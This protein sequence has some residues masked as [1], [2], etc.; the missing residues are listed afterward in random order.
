M[1]EQSGKHSILFAAAEDESDSNTPGKSPV[2]FA[3]LQASDAP[4]AV[5]TDFPSPSSLFNGR[6]HVDVFISTKSGTGLAENVFAQLVQP[7]FTWYGLKPDGNYAVHL[8]T[9]ETSV[10]ELT[11][12]IV[13]PRANEG[14]K[15]TIVLLSGDGGMVDVV[16]A[17]IAG[18]RTKDF[19]RPEIALLPFGTG[20]ALAN[21][22]GIT[23]D[24]L[25]GLRTLL[26]GHP[27]PVPVFRAS[28]SP[29]ARLLTNEGRGERELGGAIDGFPVAHG[30]VVC[31][32]GLHATLVADSDTTEYRKFGAERFKMAGKEALYP[33]DGSLPHAYKGK[34][35]VLTPGTTEWHAL[36]REGHGYILATLVSQLEAGFHISPSSQPLDGKLRLVHFGRLN[37]EDAMG[38]MTKAYQGGQHVH[39]EKVGY[40]EVEGLRVE[41]TEEDGRW[42]RVCVDGK[43]IRVEKGGWV[44]VRMGV[45]SVVDLLVR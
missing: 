4:E 17:L 14:K 35:S 22:S 15:Q 33:S 44:E 2:S 10:S 20:N 26:H 29:G 11:Q 12:Q 21:S 16:N 13:L 34:V 30:A 23:G 24:S 6:D 1:H 18:P 38:V 19:R 8:T 31:S 45:E 5:A 32:W 36:D 3:S 40:E 41:F 25:F 42:R 37:G 7:A 43:I 39:D 9:S 28:F 27:R